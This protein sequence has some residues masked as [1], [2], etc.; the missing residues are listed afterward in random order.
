MSQIDDDM[1]ETALTSLAR[2]GEVAQ[3]MMR[4]GDDVTSRASD[5]NKMVTVTVGGHGTLKNISFRGD[6]YRDLPPA[7]LA[8]ILVKTIERARQK[9]RDRAV[10]MVRDLLSDVPVVG[11]DLPRPETADEFMSELFDMFTRNVP[12]AAGRPDGPG[13]PDRKGNWT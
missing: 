3:R 10:A 4:E 9:A 5:K 2:T 6:G 1:M 11:R 7:E 8:D 13:V 12:D